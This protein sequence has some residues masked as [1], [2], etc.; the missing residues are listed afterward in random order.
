MKEEM[1]VFTVWEN[2]ACLLVMWTP[3]LIFYFVLHDVV[4]LAFCFPSLVILAYYFLKQ[5]L[6][7]EKY[8]PAAQ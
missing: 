5:V 1:R 6:W 8:K 7:E 4:F 3:F 2:F